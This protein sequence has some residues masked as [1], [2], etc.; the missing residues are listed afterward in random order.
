MV[1]NYKHKIPPKHTH[2]Y[3]V[4]LKGSQTLAQVVASGCEALIVADIQ[5]LAEHSPGKLAL[6]GPMLDL[7]ISKSSFQL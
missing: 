3:F 7:M 5:K 2:K 6:A 1:T 4:L